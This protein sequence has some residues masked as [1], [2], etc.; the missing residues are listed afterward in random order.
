[1]TIR[2]DDALT[3]DPTGGMPPE[4]DYALLEQPEGTNL[5]G[6][7]HAFW[8]FDERGQAHGYTHTEAFQ[9]FFEL[10]AERFWLTLPDGR[11]FY[12]WGD[13]YRSSK[14]APAGSNLVMTCVEPFRRWTVDFFGTVRLSYAE[15][16]AQS[17]PIEGS[18]PVARL[19]VDVEI[20]AEPWRLGTLGM[21]DNPFAKSFFGEDRY[22]QLCRFTGW[23]AIEKEEPIRL[24]GMAMRTHRRGSRRMAG[25]H[26]HSWQTA[27][28][29]SGRGFGFERFP[30][31]DGPEG[32]ANPAWS[33]GYILDEGRIVPAEILESGWLT[34]L[35]PKDED[36]TIRLRAAG[37]E[38]VIRGRT[39]ATVW[40]TIQAG[41]TT[42][43]NVRRFGIWGR[44]GDYVM[45]QGVT[46]WD[47][48]GET[49]Y[50][51]TERSTLTTDLVRP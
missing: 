4:A 2:S 20:A 30:D 12:T 25:W 51:H 24:S 29:P 5:F 10:R 48:D 45:G 23:V 35:T 26:G 36:I 19:H 37:R 49:V 16:L 31:R 28:F 43:R 7:N 27:L 22:E 33:E 38:H 11:I 46:L 9:D 8:F 50:G 13:G 42:D 44:E 32:R 21:K 15:E 6:E 17:R 14:R 41:K 47:W 39:I 1:M 18:R 40:R 34:A 3:Y